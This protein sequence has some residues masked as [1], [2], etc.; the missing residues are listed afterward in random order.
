MEV[1]E[2][3]VKRSICTEIGRMHTG[4]FALVPVISRSF[5][6]ALVLQLKV[7][8]DELESKVLAVTCHNSSGART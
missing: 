5:Q 3:A 4:I 6:P 7:A 2:W 8:L 1:A